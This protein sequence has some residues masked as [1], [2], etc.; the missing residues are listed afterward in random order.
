MEKK[1]SMLLMIIQKSPRSFAMDLPRGTGAS[2]LNVFTCKLIVRVQSV[3]YARMSIPLAFRDVGI[4][5]H[6]NRDRW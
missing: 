5:F 6:P 2:L 4:A 3:L 1:E